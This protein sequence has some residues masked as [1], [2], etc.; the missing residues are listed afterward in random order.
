MN[1][2]L[3]EKYSVTLQLHFNN[4]CVRTVKRGRKMIYGF[5]KMKENALIS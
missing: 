3:Y 2:R 5:D 1:H 4:V